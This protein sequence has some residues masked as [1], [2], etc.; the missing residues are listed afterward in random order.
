MADNN[1]KRLDENLKSQGIHANLLNKKIYE[2][3]S[4]QQYKVKVTSI[5]NWEINTFIK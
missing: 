5:L 3:N 4:Q 2:K 1:L